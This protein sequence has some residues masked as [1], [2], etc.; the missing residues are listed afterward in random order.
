M[1]GLT[2]KFSLL[3]IS[4]TAEPIEVLTIGFEESSLNELDQLLDTLGAVVK[5][6]C[7]V[8]LR[9]VN[10]A[11]YIG[12][13]KLEEILEKVKENDVKAVVIDI[14]LSPNQL[15]NL[16]RVFE[17]PT[18]DRAG[19]I[20]EIFSQHAQTK[21]AKTQV[22]VASL[23]YLKPRLAHLWTHFE[24]QG[25][26]VGQKGMG[27]KQLEVDRRLI[28][29]RINR[30]KTR[31]KTIE[32]ERTVQ[33]AGRKDVFKVALVGYTNAGKSTLLNVLTHSDVLVENKLFATLDSS[34]RTLDPDSRPPVVAIDTV[35]FIKNLPHSL[36]ASFRATLEEL[37]EADLLVH[38]LDASSSKAHE[39]LEVTEEVLKEL[40]VLD[41]P[42]MVI[43]NKKD[44][45]QDAIAL[46][47]VRIAAPQA[48]RISALD[49]ED[50]NL[51]REKILQH[52]R[53]RM[54]LWEILVPYSE[55][56]VEALLHQYGVVE[57]IRYME[58]GAF[59]RLK[60]DGQWA[61]K[62]RLAQYKL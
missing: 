16:E 57:T 60:M 24:R 6:K 21:E 47:W 13:G 54:E 35:G 22:E 37:H 42:R 52:F 11:T 10:A 34:V 41:K 32:K 28:E 2:G 48:I 15:R 45:I 29:D 4:D 7:P 33:R 3:P 20:L 44:L 58:K 59:F 12:K 14:D 61:Q 5:V 8:V 46:N 38:V 26:G 43:L 51:L 40:G 9:Q 18:L 30:L 50:V 17:R 55:G 25:G 56:K 31:L 53:D 1:F 36:V 39:E 23:Q 27:E 62:L 49:S 19:V